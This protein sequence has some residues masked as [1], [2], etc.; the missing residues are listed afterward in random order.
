[1]FVPWR[2]QN[3]LRIAEGFSYWHLIH[4]G[5]IIDNR[6]RWLLIAPYDIN[7]P[8]TVII[9]VATFKLDVKDNWNIY[10]KVIF[11]TENELSNSSKVFSVLFYFMAIIS[12]LLINQ[13]CHVMR[14]MNSRI[15]RVNELRAGLLNSFFY[16][17]VWCFESLVATQI[18]F[19]IMLK[20]N[21]PIR[22]PFEIFKLSR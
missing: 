10:F 11:I 3:R 20:Q 15:Y 22:A 8:W 7:K 4:Y 12:G 5:S 17:W 9:N 18:H 13:A 2:S 16:D 1:M 21:K 19:Q 6:G 14:R